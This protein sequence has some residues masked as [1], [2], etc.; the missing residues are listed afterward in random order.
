[1]ATSPPYSHVNVLV[2]LAN[3]STIVFLVEILK[4]QCPLGK[5]STAEC[6]ANVKLAFEHGILVYRHAAAPC[7]TYL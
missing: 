3:T 7:D 6:E 1:M 4:R 5:C 2:A